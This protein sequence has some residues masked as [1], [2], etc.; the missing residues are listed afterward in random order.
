MT[1]TLTLEAHDGGA[2]RLA[3]RRRIRIKKSAFF[4][5]PCRDGPKGNEQKHDL[6]SAG[7]AVRKEE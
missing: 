6:S 5:V 7:D 4:I 1:S 2:H 3:A